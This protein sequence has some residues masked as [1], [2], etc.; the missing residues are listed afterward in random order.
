MP[1]AAVSENGDG[2]SLQRR[3]VGVALIENSSHGSF[4]SSDGRT[5]R[6][7]GISIYAILQ[8]CLSQERS[9]DRKDHF[10]EANSSFPKR[11]LPYPLQSWHGRGCPPPFCSDRAGYFGV[12]ICSKRSTLQRDSACC[13]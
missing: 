3:R 10:S 1:L 2:L 6:S 12:T 9:F 4:S 5:D 11:G 13:R 8:I 7:V